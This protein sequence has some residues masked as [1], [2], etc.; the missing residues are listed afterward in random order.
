[1]EHV[2]AVNTGA[3]ERYLLGELPDDECA[4]FEEH[5]FSCAECAADVRA[6]A[7]FVEGAVHV[8]SN[9]AGAASAAADPAPAAPSGSLSRFPRRGLAWFFPM[10]LGAAAALVLSVVGLAWQG[11]VALP[12]AR[13][14]LARATAPQPASW[15]FLSVSRAE[16]QVVTVGRAEGWLGLTLS[17]SSAEAFEYYRCRLSREGAAPLEW[18][19]PAP[20]PGGELQTALPLLRMSPGRYELAIE[21]LRGA[22][23]PVGAPSVARYKFSLRY[24]GE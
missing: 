24:R 14:E 10:P 3:T 23:G 19:V 13:R 8:L 11:L 7:E 4:A 16:P 17:R 15:A 2:E 9:G 18:T 22:D 6:A 12:S 1:M 21:G 20:E 5:Y